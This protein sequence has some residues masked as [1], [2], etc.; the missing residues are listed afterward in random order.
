MSRTA[1]WLS[2]LALVWAGCGAQTG[3]IDDPPEPVDRPVPH[4]EV[5][6][7]LDDDLDGL[8]S[9]GVFDGGGMDASLVVGRRRDRRRR[10]GRERLRRR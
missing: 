6:N 8:V 9:V 1:A 2:I 3:L 5:C 4:P 7:G 10:A